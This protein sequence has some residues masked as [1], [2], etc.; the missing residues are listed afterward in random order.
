MATTQSNQ[1]ALIQNNSQ[2]RAIVFSALFVVILY[3]LWVSARLKIDFYDSSLI[4]LNAKCIA[5]HSIQNYTATR[6]II[7]PIVLSPI[8]TILQNAPQ[9][10]WITAHVTMIIFTGILLIMVYRFFQLDLKA[11]YALF[12]LFLLSMNRT[13]LHMAPFCKEDVFALLLL[14][15]A[16]YLYLR[17]CQSRLKRYYIGSGIIISLAI[18]VRYNFPILFAVLGFYEL[19][20]GQIKFQNSPKH[21]FVKTQDLRWKFLFLLILPLLLF[22]FILSWHYSSLGISG[23]WNAPKTYILGPVARMAGLVKDLYP[24]PPIYVFIFL[25]KCSSWPVVLLAAWGL[26]VSLRRKNHLAWF[27]ILWLLVFL[28]PQMTIPQK[29][30]RFLIAVL[31]PLYYLAM[32]GLENTWGHLTAFTQAKAKSI[33][34]STLRLLI[35]LLVVAAPFSQALAELV[36]FQDPVYHKDFAK[37]IAEYAVKL[38]DDRKIYWT[39][40]FYPVH[41]KDYIFHVEDVTYYIHHL[42]VTGMKLLS[43]GNFSEIRNAQFVTPDFQ[44]QPVFIGPNAGAMLSN[45][46]VLIVNPSGDSFFTKTLPASLPPIF[47]ERVQK[48]HFFKTKTAPGGAALFLS[49]AA[50]GTMIEAQPT[51]Q[52]FYIQGTHLPD[53][54]YEIYTRFS[55]VDQFVPLSIVDAAG[56]QFKYLQTDLKQFTN[57]EEIY[58]LTFEKVKTFSLPQTN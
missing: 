18:G 55:G 12:G 50:D 32:I 41:P 21:F 35:I 19:L 29:E 58:L 33:K 6:P 30:A 8:F 46:D 14:T 4:L 34:T 9:I 44:N 39:G 15:S 38:A 52:G 20:S 5:T 3:L 47:V 1:P 27:H 42:G 40:P 2:F 49:P 17:G 13:F 54:R 22:A 45:G 37:D 36:Q 23:F 53:G 43:H 7:L 10:A 28:V 56:G 26:L 48:I 24:L 25:V 51:P 11:P 31:P 16:Y 57:A